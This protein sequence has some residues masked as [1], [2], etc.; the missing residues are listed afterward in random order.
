M[1]PQTGLPQGGRVGDFDTYALMKLNAAGISTDEALKVLGKAAG[2]AG[3]SGVS[4]DMREIEAA[5]ADGNAQAQLA[6]DVFVESLRHY[7]GAYL[8][9]TNGTDAICFTGGIGQYG[10]AIRARAMA[11]MDYAGIVID[12]TKNEAAK[13]DEESRVESNDSRTQIWVLPT[14]EE[15]IVARQTADV[16]KEQ[17]SETRRGR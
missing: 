6:I 3:L 10:K 15:L 7:I 16:L 12:S 1:T 14:N 11:G 4:S 13:G 9:A 5:A 2:L 8:A 17:T